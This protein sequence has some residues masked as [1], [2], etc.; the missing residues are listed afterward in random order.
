MRYYHVFL[1]INS[2]RER[3]EKNLDLTVEQLEERYLKPYRE[4]G[5]IITKG[6]T[7]DV[8]DVE[9][10]QIKTTMRKAESMAPSVEREYGID[11]KG[12]ILSNFLISLY[13]KERAQDVSDKYIIGPPGYDSTD[14]QSTPPK[15][16][17][18]VFVVHGRNLKARAALFGFLRSIDLKPLEWSKLVQNTGKTM[19]YIG[20]I[21]DG[22]FA[23]AHA[24]IVLIT[25]DDEARLKENL[26]DS[27][28]PPHEM[29]LTGQARANVLFEAG[30]AIGRSPERTIIVELGTLRPFSDIAG[31]HTVRL[32]NSSQKRQ[33]L[34]DRLKTAGCPIDLNGTEWHNCGDFE[35]A[36]ADSVAYHEQF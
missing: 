17:K 36:V 21:L 35:S 8:K 30:M 14:S 19:P 34:A 4:G 27:N 20:E 11:I 22:A 18:E 25:P 3:H 23:Q 5:S 33:E 16:A 24:V 10:M 32:D 7:I 28:D 9:R 13:I 29:E 1:T 12:N 2:R 6:R 26:R 15:N 31:L